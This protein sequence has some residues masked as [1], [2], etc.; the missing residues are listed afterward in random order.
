MDIAK[1]LLQ[2]G[3]LSG[4]VILAGVFLTKYADTLGERT[5]LGRSLAG[6]VLLA[7]ATSLPELAVGASAARMAASDPA[8]IG[9]ADLAVGGLMGSCLFNLGIL[10]VLD[11][12]FRSHGRMLSRTAAAHA[13]SSTASVVLMGT[14]LLFLLLGSTDAAWA[15]WSLGQ[16]GLRYFDVGLGTLAIGATYLISLRLVYFDQQH[17]AD[18]LVEESVV[19]KEA[20]APAQSLWRAVVGYVLATAVIF[21]AAPYMAETADELATVTGLGQ[22]FVGTTLVAIATSLPEVVTTWTALRIG[23][24]DMAVGNIFGSNSFNMVILLIVDAFFD[25][26]SL[27]SAVPGSQVHAVTAA[28]AIIVTAVATMGLLYRAEK[29]LWFVEPDALVI[30]LMVLGAMG[31]IYLLG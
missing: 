9:A 1:L 25:Q 12:I 21:M 19:E 5:G 6:L 29:R 24:F 16:L 26:G 23:A 2:F 11:I 3:G 31:L 4:I 22:T 27:L 13:L 17:V 30:I 18:V 28:A 7:A 15:D 10:A 14:A 20:D 8:N